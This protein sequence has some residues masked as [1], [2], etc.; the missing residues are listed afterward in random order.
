[1][2]QKL[3]TFYFADTVSLERSNQVELVKLR[4]KRQGTHWA[5]SSQ[6][7][8]RTPYPL[9]TVRTASSLSLMSPWLCPV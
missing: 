4:G 8:T 2:F 9:S 3:V 7:A 1:M 6:K 5:L